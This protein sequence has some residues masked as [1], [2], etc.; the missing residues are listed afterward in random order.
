[1][2][3]LRYALQEKKIPKLT[4]KPAHNLGLFMKPIAFWTLPTL[5]GRLIWVSALLVQQ[6][7]ISWVSLSWCFVAASS[8][9]KREKEITDKISIKHVE[10]SPCVTAYFDLLSY[11]YLSRLIHGTSLI[12]YKLS[13]PPARLQHVYIR[14]RTHVNA[15]RTYLLSRYLAVNYLTSQRVFSHSNFLFC[16]HIPMLT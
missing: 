14:T 6:A 16:T 5:Y 15:Y 2:I 8:T 10:Y 9:K 11:L 7:A 3:Q 13:V 1:M 12:I 4:M